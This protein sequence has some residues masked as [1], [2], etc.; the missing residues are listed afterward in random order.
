MHIVL[1]DI[2]LLMGMVGNGKVLTV[3]ALKSVSNVVE[4]EQQQVTLQEALGITV[5]KIETT[6]TYVHN[7]GFK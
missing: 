6:G 3:V 1:V 2:Q 5:K 7:V 4:L